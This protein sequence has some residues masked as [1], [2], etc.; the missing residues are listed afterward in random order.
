MKKK[1]LISK[2][3]L[4]KNKSKKILTILWEWVKVKKINK[5]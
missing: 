1:R 2:Y 5:L 4:N 3:K